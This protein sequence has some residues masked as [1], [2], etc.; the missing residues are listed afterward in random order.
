MT[1]SSGIQPVE[2]KVLVKPE[3]VEM[4]TE[5]GIYLP[6]STQEKEKFAVVK[7]RLVAVGA[8]AFTEPNWL[9]CPQ[10]GD[11]ILFDRYSGSFVEGADGEEYKL[12]NDK[13]IGAI[14]NE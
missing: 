6:D 2:Y 8:N 11:L 10:I 7:G 3:K 5:G 4:K 14:I 1:N 12:I 9:R 13:E